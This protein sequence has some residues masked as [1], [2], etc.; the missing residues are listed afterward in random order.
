MFIDTLFGFS[1]LFVLMKILRKTQMSALTPFDF[2]SA[3]IIGELVG[4][5]LY[6]KKAGIP[7]IAF[8]II[9]WGGLLYTVEIISQKFMRT[10]YIIEGKPSIII[11]KGKLIREIMRKNKIDISEVQQLL[12]DKDV[13][14]VQEVEYGILE[15]NGKISVLKKSAYQVP[16]K[17][18][19]NIAPVDIFLPYTLINDGEIITDNVKEAG[20]HKEWLE[21]E[22]KRQG[23]DKV[24]DVFYA[25]YTEGKKLFVLP[26]TK[27]TKRKSD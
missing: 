16:N 25:E 3:V 17:K 23:F 12:R 20:L 14:S 11:H 9:L 5:A 7:E 27:Q 4:N 1:A 26:F 21:K 22:L 18:D 6:D 19:L 10:R 13:F 24:E 8:V 15:A 2:I